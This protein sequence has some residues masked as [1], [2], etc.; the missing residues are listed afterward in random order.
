MGDECGNGSLLI[1]VTVSP[2]REEWLCDRECTMAR[3]DLIKPGFDTN[4][5]KL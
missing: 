2:A 4:Y 5:C 3:L 1:M